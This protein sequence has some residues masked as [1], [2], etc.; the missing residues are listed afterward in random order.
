[1]ISDLKP[2]LV[3]TTSQ[4]VTDGQFHMGFYFMLATSK[5]KVNQLHSHVLPNFICTLKDFSWLNLYF[6]HYH[7]LFY[8]F[9][10][11]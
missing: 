4:C 9:E 8:I 10:M 11:F 1:M 2:D 7:F 5:T 3:L 6:F